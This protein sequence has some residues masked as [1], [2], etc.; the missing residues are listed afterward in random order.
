[1]LPRHTRKRLRNA[2][3]HRVRSRFAVAL[4][5]LLFTVL[6]LV[7]MPVQAQTRSKKKVDESKLKAVYMYSFGKYTTWPDSSF[8]KTN[9]DIVVGVYGD[10]PVMEQLQGVAAKRKLHKRSIRVV[11]FKSA[12]D[13]VPAHM[14]FVS[15]DLPFEQQQK[16]VSRLMRQPVLIVGETPQFNAVGGAVSFFLT[17]DSKVKFEID[18]QNAKASGLGLD[19][20]LLRL[21]SKRPAPT[22]LVPSVIHQ[23]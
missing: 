13:Y 20:K 23:P 11:Y 22:S 19:A 6:S 16:I 17:G 9:G 2:A 1:M 14:V 12:E 8:E 21:G 10:S 15:K 5:A 4:V 7:A 3:I 18:G